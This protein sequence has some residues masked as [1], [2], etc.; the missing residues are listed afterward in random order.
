MPRA[1]IYLR[2][3]LAPGKT[4]HNK[5]ALEPLLTLTDLA[6][7]RYGANTNE[8]AISLEFPGSK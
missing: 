2:Q 6:S 4:F 1:G 3:L 5:Q 7:Q 8:F